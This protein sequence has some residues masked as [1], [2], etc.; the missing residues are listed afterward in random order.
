MNLLKIDLSTLKETASDN[1]YVY[2]PQ[3]LTN[4]GK[5]NG[6]YF[7]LAHL[8]NYEFCEIQCS[9]EQNLRRT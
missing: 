4:L 7:Y 8:G 1:V 2:F 9:D 3:F 5:M 6:K